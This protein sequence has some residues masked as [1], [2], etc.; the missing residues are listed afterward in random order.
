M[1]KAFRITA[2]S[3]GSIV[4]VILLAALIIFLFFPGLP[5]YLY[6]TNQ[7]PDFSR[8]SE[9]YPYSDT[10]VPDSFVEFSA[11]EIT[12]RIPAELY[13]KYP[14]ETEG[15]K[16]NLYIND[17]ESSSITF[18]YSGKTEFGEFSLTD[19]ESGITEEQIADLLQN[20][21]KSYP[22]SYYEFYHLIYSL[23]MDDFNIH[24]HKHAIGFLAIPML[25]EMLIPNYDNIYE[26]S[27]ENGVGFVHQNNP[28]ED[29]PRYNFVVSLFDAENPDVCYD[30][31]ISANDIEVAK[32]IIASIELNK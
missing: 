22:E 2:I 17:D 14:E 26:F 21:G 31:I 16:S 13:K 27:T 25:K 3:L 11:D 15:M 32:Q 18:I 9:S 19:E 29:L 28:T 7:Y 6:I 30:I 10:A 5:T 12:A 4:G 24:S 1:K 20:M 8:L 23:T